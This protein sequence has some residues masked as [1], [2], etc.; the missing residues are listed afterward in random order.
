[1]LLGKTLSL[2][3][4]MTNLV[5]WIGI[6]FF[7]IHK[8]YKNNSSQAI[9]YLLYYKLLIGGIISLSIACIK[10][11][12]LTIIY[13]GIHHLIITIILT[14]QLL[15]YRVKNHNYISIP[16]I[17][18]DSPN[19]YNSKY[20]LSTNEIICSGIITPVVFVLLTIV[21]ITH[22]L[23][24]IEILAWFAN[25]LFTTSKFT[26]IYKNYKKQS[27]QGLSRTSFI[28]MIFTDLLFLASLFINLID[29]QETLS[30]IIFK[31]LQW[32]T[33]CSISLISGFVIQYQ[34][35][36]YS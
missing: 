20:Y 31:N 11:T 27:T 29:I 15:Y 26:Q 34:F 23:I 14:S 9:S 17:I 4:G 12:N 18:S 19:V 10:Q 5:V 1:M 16:N 32:I 6:A 13:I 22:N 33:S 25:I 35:R 30:D 36:L 28:C 24:L 2:I 8:N 7:Q 3:F 21:Y